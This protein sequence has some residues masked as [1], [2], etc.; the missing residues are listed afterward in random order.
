MYLAHQ[1]YLVDSIRF[2]NAYMDET[3]RSHCYLILDLPQDTN[4]GLRFRT[5]IFP[6][7]YPP[8]VYSDKGDEACEI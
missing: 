2:Y 4:D 3:R 7:E 6:T 1:V 8:V 5:N